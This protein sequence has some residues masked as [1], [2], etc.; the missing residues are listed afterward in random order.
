MLY[1]ISF[2]K[3]SCHRK[4][5][6]QILNFYQFMDMLRK[7]Y[8]A[9]LNCAHIVL[10]YN[11]LSKYL[12]YVELKDASE[13]TGGAYWEVNQISIAQWYQT[14]G[15]SGVVILGLN[16]LEPHIMGAPMA[17]HSNWGAKLASL[18]TFEAERC[19]L[20]FLWLMEKQ[21]NSSMLFFLQLSSQV[22]VPLLITVPSNSNGFA[23]FFFFFISFIL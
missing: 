21:S 1:R 8:T 20:I 11:G 14:F 10:N 4:E 5:K 18:L 15:G 13:R 19:R 6:N 23:V 3:L 16:V 7:D 2:K 22:A 12:V 17:M 9:A